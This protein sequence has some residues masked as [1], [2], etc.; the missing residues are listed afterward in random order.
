[1]RD[2]PGDVHFHVLTP[3]SCDGC[4]LC[5]LGIGSPVLWYASHYQTLTGHPFRP[6]GLPQQLIDEIDTAFDGLM[7]GQEPQEQ[8]LWFN[9][10][11]RKCRHYEWRPQV[12]KDYELGGTACLTARSPHSDNVASLRDES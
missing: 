8:C 2:S 3:Q 5:C 9:A 10:T 1:M 11:T 7:R 12:C 4:G 6:A